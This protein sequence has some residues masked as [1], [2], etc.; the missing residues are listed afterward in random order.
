MALSPIRMVNK[1]D[2][3]VDNNDRYELTIFGQH[4]TRK[5]VV[6]PAAKEGHEGLARYTP[7]LS[8]PVKRVRAVR[9]WPL[10]GDRRYSLG[11]LIVK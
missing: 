3:S 10:G 7:E 2:V 4:E 5:I 11:H 8:P 1:I 9:L 6:G